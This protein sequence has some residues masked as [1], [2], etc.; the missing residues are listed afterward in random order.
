VS[1][2]WAYLIVGFGLLRMMPITH[3]SDHSNSP[4]FVAVSHPISSLQL[5]T[6]SIHILLT[7]LLITVQLKVKCF[8]KKNPQIPQ[9]LVKKNY[10]RNFSLNW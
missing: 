4:L 5:Q 10:F 2:S 8:S 7:V 9:F 3:F 1:L 6:Q